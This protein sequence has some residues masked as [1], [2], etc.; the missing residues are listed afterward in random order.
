MDK[1]MTFKEAMDE[2]EE[3]VRQMEEGNVE[4]EKSIEQFTRGMELSKYCVKKLESMERQICEITAED[5]SIEEKPF[6]GEGA[7]DL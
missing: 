5:G 7:D 2:L 4:I 6:T 3:I 1:E